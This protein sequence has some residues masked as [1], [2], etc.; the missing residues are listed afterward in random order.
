MKKPILSAVVGLIAAAQLS[1]TEEPFYLDLKSL[2]NTDVVLEQGGSGLTEPLDPA[3]DRLDANSLPASYQDGSAVATQ[4]GTARFKFTTLKQSGLDALAIDGQLLDVPDRA[5]GSVDLALLSAPDNYSSPF[6][7]LEFR[8]TDGTKESRRFGP[9]PGWMASPTAFDHSLFR[10][11]DSS[12]VNTLI[13]FRTDFGDEE[14]AYIVQLRGNGNS[15]GNRFIDAAGYALYRLPIPTDVS[16][17]TL[18]ITVGNNFVVSLAAEFHDPEESFTE[19]Y[20]EVANSMTLYDGLEHR[21]LQNLKLY[22]FDLAPFLASKTGEIYVLLTDATPGNGWGPYL[23]NMSVYTGTNITFEETLTPAVDRSRAT[24]YAEFLTNGGDAEKPYL[25]DN[26]GSGPSNRGHRFADGTGSITYRFDLPDDVTDAKLTADLANNFV[27]SVAGPS[28]IVRYVQVAPGSAEEKNFL[29]DEGNSILGGNYRFADATAYMIYQ[30]DLPDEVTTGV[31]R[32]TIGNTFVVSLASGTDGEF[33]VVK[34]WAA[35]T[36]EETHDNSNLGAYDFPLDSYLANNPQ[37]IVRIQLSDGQPADGWGPYLTDISIVNEAGTG[38]Q[39]FKEVLN[40]M[41]L[42]G[43]DV[44]TELNKAYYT[45]DLN[46]LL[47]ASNPKKEVFVKFTD[48]STADGWGPGIF[49]LAVYSGTLDIDSDEA[50]FEGLKAM[51]GDP[52]FRGATL[53]HR[54]YPLNAAKELKEIALP[55]DSPLESSKVYLLAATLNPA[56]ASA[57]PTLQAQ[58]MGDSVRISW[59]ADAP[60]FVLQ[61]APAVNGPWTPE[62]AA[63]QTQGNESVVT[64]SPTGPAKYYRL[65]KP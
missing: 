36:G 11:V 9:V 41:T 18:G 19:G 23:Q 25:Y 17:A 16:A 44:R 3:R 62:T 2:F 14:A 49:W 29:V 48:Q 37:K 57:S 24:V 52:E 39:E 15:G 30:F 42:F 63:V 40:S 51:N 33:Q 59:P 12:S 60:G 61:S 47:T 22:E 32:I 45:L 7:S 5:Y 31:A 10:Y 35:E 58:R 46:S 55:P 21:A 1:A 53:L 13:T 26:S 65:T 8:Y 6:S 34:D 28:S 27:V 64:V 4:S 38:G 54:R 50:V 20:T 56:Q 43:V